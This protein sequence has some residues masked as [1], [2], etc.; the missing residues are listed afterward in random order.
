L[1]GGTV[2]TMQPVVTTTC[3]QVRGATTD[4]VARFLGIPYAAA[5]V[6]PLRFQ[7]P[8]PVQ[9]WDGVRDAVEFGPTPPKPAYPPPMDQILF[10]RSV[11]GDDWLSVNVWAPRSAWDG[12]RESGLPVMVW[13]HGGAFQNGNSAL[14]VYDGTAFARDGVVFVSLNYRLGIDGFAYLPD[15]P[16]NRGL[17]DQIAALEWVRDNISAFGG[18]PE[19]VTVFGE[20]AGAMSVTLLMTTPRAQGLFAKAIGQSGSVQAAAAAADAALVAGEVSTVLGVPATAEELSKVEIDD[21]VRAQR[22]VSAALAADRDPAR[23]GESVVRASMAFLPVVDGELITQHPMAVFAA[24]QAADIPLLQGTTTDEYRLFL[25]PTGLAG[26][27]SED[28][29]TALSAGVGVP[30]NVRELY[31]ANRKEGTPG[32]VFAALLTDL[33]FRLPAL[34]T[35]AAHRGPSFVYEFA[36]RSSEG[37]LWAC[38]G[39]DVTYVFDTLAASGSEGLA[40]PNPS[41]AVATAIHQAWVSFATTGDPGWARY[42][43]TR[44]VMVF[45]DPAPHLELDPR[46]DERA[47][48]TRHASDISRA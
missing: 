36:Q 41:Q 46:G 25:I 14:P 21:L 28:M 37:D 7:A 43:A 20:S 19:N 1:G 27:M 29:L 3:G 23:F 5:P 40:G 35:V 6:G 8:A 39:L 47:A 12:D 45:E 24:G 10:E 17:L 31:R 13:I 34:A 30:E 32:D 44:P 18:D 48:W 9:P 4:G 16:A 11:P 42:D 22:T 2:L 33:F 38:H 26:F 15:A